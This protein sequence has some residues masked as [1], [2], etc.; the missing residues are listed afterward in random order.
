MLMQNRE[1]SDIEHIL[2]TNLFSSHCFHGVFLGPW[3]IS[4]LCLESMLKPVEAL[5]RPRGTAALTASS[6]QAM[7]TALIQ[8]RRRNSLGG[9]VTA[10]GTDENSWDA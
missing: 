10:V 7:N 9:R 5:H 1:A 2:S 6:F 4:V 8:L 3:T